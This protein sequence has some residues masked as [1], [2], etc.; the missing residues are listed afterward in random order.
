MDDQ[1]LGRSVSSCQNNDLIASDMS[2]PP[3]SMFYLDVFS[4]PFKLLFCA[5]DNACRGACPWTGGNQFDSINE[6]CH[7]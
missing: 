5:P 6:P 3:S 1:T 4:A 2:F 7:L